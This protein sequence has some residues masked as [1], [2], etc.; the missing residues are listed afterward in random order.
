MANSLFSPAREGFLIGEINWSTA[1][2]KAALVRSY[3]LNTAHKFVSDVTTAGGEIVATTAALAGK[4]HTG[5]IADADDSTFGM[6]STGSACNVILLYQ[7]S[8]V[9]GGADVG[10]TAQRLIAYI[11]SATN[12]PVT[13]NGGEITLAWSSGS[14]KIFRI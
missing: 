3:V 9:G 4:T 10:D 12:L 8:A 14:D 1:T 11:D 7:S 6:V 5:G 13:P 2:I